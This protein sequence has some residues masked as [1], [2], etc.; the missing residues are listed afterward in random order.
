MRDGYC[1]LLNLTI[2][3]P[4][5]LFLLH[6]SLQHTAQFLLLRVHPHTMLYPPIDDLLNFRES[7]SRAKQNRRIH[8]T[9]HPLLL[10]IHKFD[11]PAHYD[12]VQV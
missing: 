1:F 2:Y 5:Y 11:L 6:P 3:N 10:I 9:L 12:Y 8:P 7:R 4:L